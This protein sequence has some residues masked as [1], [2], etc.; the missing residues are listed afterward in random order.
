MSYLE[1]YACIGVRV[2]MCGLPN[3]KKE[4]DKKEKETCRCMATWVGAL[5][6]YEGAYLACWYVITQARWSGC[7]GKG[8]VERVL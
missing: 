2:M 1:V 3:K 7:V 5:I 8:R 6:A 4:K